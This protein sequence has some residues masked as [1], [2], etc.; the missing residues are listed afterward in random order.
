M[1]N[2]IILKTQVSDLKQ[3]TNIKVLETPY[4]NKTKGKAFEFMFLKKISLS[5]K[6]IFGFQIKFSKYS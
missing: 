1:K 3:P 5:L 4:Q 6:F 2:T